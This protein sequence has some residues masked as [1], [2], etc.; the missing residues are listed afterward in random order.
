MKSQKTSDA[1]VSEKG[2]TRSQLIR[3]HVASNPGLS[4]AAIVEQMTATGTPVSVNLVY[5]V[6]RQTGET[7]GKEPVT[8]KAK[9]VTIKTAK[10]DTAGP[11]GGAIHSPELFMKMLD[12]V[13]GAGGLKQATEILQKL[14][15]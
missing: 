14:Q 7:T 4:A 11:K 8:R 3:N 10:P 13:K 15:G 6:L 2:V 5:Q 1:V 9:P 12:F